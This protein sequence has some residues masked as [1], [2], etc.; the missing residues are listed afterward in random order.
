MENAIREGIY[1]LLKRMPI[2]YATNYENTE[3][4][5]KIGKDIFVREFLRQY[6]M[7][8]EDEVNHIYDLILKRGGDLPHTAFSLLKEIA[9]EYLYLSG[10]DIS[11]HQNK[12]LEFRQVS[13]G[14]GQHIFISMFEAARR[15]KTGMQGML[16]YDSPIIKSDDLRLKHILDNGIAENHFHLNG[17]A[18]TAMLS[19]ICLMNHPSKRDREFRIFDERRNFFS[20]S[21]EDHGSSLQMAVITAAA[22]RLKLYH[23]LNG[24][25][26]EA[27]DIQN[28]LD[29]YRMGLES[30]SEL[31]LRIDDERNLM[32]KEA[33]DYIPFSAYREQL[34]YPIAGEREFLVDLFGCILDENT[35]TQ[36]DVGEMYAY[37]L[38]YCRFYGEMVQSNQAVGFY[39]FMRYQDRKEVF[40]DAHPRYS[41]QVKKM[42]LEMALA[43]EFLVSLE[44]RITPKL[45]KR[46]LVAQ[47]RLYS[48]KIFA[49]DTIRCSDCEYYDEVL[50]QCS[51]EQCIRIFDRLFFVY[52]F[53]KVPDMVAERPD[54][55]INI[56]D[57]KCRHYELRKKNIWPIIWKFNKLRKSEKV[58]DNVY[59]LD[60]CNR[61]ID[62]RPE[63]FAPY[64]RFAREQD[65]YADHDIFGERNPPKLRITYH[66]GEDFLDVLDGLRAIEEAV[67]FMELKS[68]DRIGHALALGVDV[69]NWYMF[70]K[71][72]VYLSSQDAL[73][74]TAFLYR[75]IMEHRLDY[76]MLHQKLEVD[77]HKYLHKIYPDLPD[78]SIH[79]YILSMQLRGDEPAIYRE[80]E[81]DSFDQ[82]AEKDWKRLDNRFTREASSNRM[83]LRL[84][85]QYHYNHRAKYEGS[86]PVELEITQEY[87]N[88]VAEVQK[89]MCHKVANLGIGIE[90][91]LS[92][93][94]LVGV[95]KQYIEHPIL[96]FNH[97]NLRSSK[98]EGI[99]EM[100]VSINTDD[101]GV[102]DTNLENEYALMLCAL[103]QEADDHGH[104]KFSLEEIYRWL[105]NIRRMGIEQSFKFSDKIEGK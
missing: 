29:L 60:A 49:S 51:K 91:N 24:R 17:S 37:L 99:P 43:P 40:L 45:T 2:S 47:Q 32:P 1:I 95:A 105:D 71:M 96:R 12:M 64:F 5:K 34:F 30:V 100:F 55:G 94:I 7:Y 13:M 62:C 16:P 42:A 3:S 84:I 25:K 23:I 61:E 15:A 46:E 19:W 97:Y 26:Q 83:A 54:T 73:D 92:S 88:A 72:R 59:G 44:A 58:F 10:R 74:N 81:R 93:N 8:S 18:P 22:I 27:Q 86:M 38:I 75:M 6:H 57:L 103:Q 70:K 82:L 4:Y 102:F 104:M 79:E 80:W 52:H 9:E 69:Q 48:K 21:E 31:Q 98:D 63:V 77:F 90:C 66:V 85:H 67:T 78:A 89:I 11:C 68:G 76:P 35:D 20:S 14:I 56:G 65:T 36:H 39:N 50:E 87:I 33:L 101:L 53:V 28:W 41:Y